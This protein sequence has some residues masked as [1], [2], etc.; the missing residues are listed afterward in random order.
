MKIKILVVL[1]FAFFFA[2]TIKA[3]TVINGNPASVKWVQINTDTVRII[4]P[5]YLSAKARRVSDY[6]HHLAKNNI[7]SLGGKVRKI[8]IVMQANTVNPNGYVS[9]TPYKSEFYCNK[10]SY[11]YNVHYKIYALV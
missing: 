8:N 6:I 1:V 10:C 11:S 4:F 7:A 5:E 3:Q 9:L 2:N